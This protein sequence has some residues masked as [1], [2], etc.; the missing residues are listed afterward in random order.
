MTPSEGSRD[1]VGPDWP[2]PAEIDDRPTVLHVAEALGGGLA[3]AL[4]DYVRS[5]PEYRHVLLSYRRPDAPTGDSLDELVTE[6]LTLPHG[7]L[8]R[9]RAIRQ[10]LK[11]LR[12]NVVHAHS[13]F[14]GAYTRLAAGRWRR[15]VVYT[16]HCFAFERTDVSLALRAGFWLIEAA[17]SLT[18]GYLAASSPREAALA[19]RLSSRTTMVYVPCSPYIPPIEPREPARKNGRGLRV[20]MV[21]R[22]VAQKDPQFFACA[23]RASRERSPDT[24]WIWIGGGEPT[25]DRLLRSAGVEVTGWLTRAESLQRLRTADV[26][27]H[28]AA[29]EATGLTILEAA[30]LGLPILARAIPATRSLGLSNLSETPEALAFAVHR[31]ND[32]RVRAQLQRQSQLLL[33]RHRPALQ[34]RALQKVYDLASSRHAPSRRMPLDPRVRTSSG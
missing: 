12:P 18:G 17:L 25:Y 14:A 4:E 7:H 21:G 33:E 8:A 29:W 20:M 6:H 27:V 5:T 23:A 9:L 32:E 30:A 10:Q 16:P 3:T 24:Q 28:T 31:A 34:Q 19:R 26:Y 2:S 11:R 22:L 13:S 1:G 15:S